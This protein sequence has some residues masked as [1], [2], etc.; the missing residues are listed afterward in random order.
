MVR[1]DRET[2]PDAPVGHTY[3]SVFTPSE[4]PYKRMSALDWADEEETLAV[5]DPA[6]RP[7]ER[8]GPEARRPDHDAFWGSIV[9][10]LE[11]GRW[12]PLPSVAPDSR[13]LDFRTEPPS[14]PG[15]LEFSR[16]GADNFFVRAT[17]TGGAGGRRRLIWLT[18]APQLYFSGATPDSRLDEQ[19]RALLR[20]LPPH[21]RRTALGVLDALGLH[22]TPRSSLR[23][24]LDPLVAHFRSFDT[25]T[26][27][28][29]SGS[30]YR[31][32]ALG[33]KGVCRH[34]AF[35]FLITALAAGIPARYV[36]NELH[37]FVEVHV[38]RIGWRRIN[39]GGAALDD[40][41][42]GAEDKPMHRPRRDDE[43]PRPPEFLAHATP[44]A[45]RSGD[46]RATSG[47]GTG[48]GIGTDGSRG[49]PRVDL[50]AVIEA[51]EAASRSTP[52]KIVTTMHIRVDSRV[53]FRGDTVEVSGEVVERGG[54]PGAD[55][56]VDI[57]L[58]GAPGAERVAQTRTGPD[59]RFVAVVLVPAG[60]QL[61]SYHVV[62]RSGG[63]ARRRP[64]SSRER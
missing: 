24:V 36:E 27:P 51:D 48:A 28:V 10:D 47:R 3:H 52:G 35:A 60:L 8:I 9:V 43:L 34:R 25:G 61:G 29:P 30:T 59:G 37:V 5:F 26:L 56:P 13:L 62:A 20:P 55:L 64:S 53:A 12:V 45:H 58:D 44:P 42:A 6:R 4:F 54:G 18:D 40:R 41:L 63:D 17:L 14:R 21:L 50:D 57:Y 39:L 49:G 31:D 19:P 23:S 7:V 46:G 38:P 2:G 1:M 22:A 16:D 33:K 11:P 15:A 32:L